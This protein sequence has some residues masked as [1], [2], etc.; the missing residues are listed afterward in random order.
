[1]GLK[2]SD[3]S[4]KFI[5]KSMLHVQKGKIKK[6]IK[7]LNKAMALDPCN[8]DIAHQVV[9]LYQRLNDKFNAIETFKNN[10]DFIEKEKEKNSIDKVKYNRAKLL[11]YKGILG[12]DPANVE[13]RISVAKSYL[14]RKK[15]RIAYIELYTALEHA[16]VMENAGLLEKIKSIMKE[17]KLSVLERDLLVAEFYHRIKDETAY[18]K[19][20]NR[21]EEKYKTKIKLL[22]GIYER[23]LNFYPYDE[24]IV[25]KYCMILI[26][27]KEYREANS[28]LRKV[29][30]CLPDNVSLQE[31]IG[32][33]AV[34]LGFLEE[35]M[36]RFQR[37]KILYERDGQ[38]E[39]LPLLMKNIELLGK[40]I[41]DKSFPEDMPP[42]PHTRTV[43]YGD[44]EAIEE[45]ETQVS[46][47]IE[48]EPDEDID[49]QV[50]EVD[51]IK[52]DLK[53]AAMREL[54]G[55]EEQRKTDSG[56]MKS[57]EIIDIGKELIEFG[58]VQE[59]DP[60]DV[61]KIDDNN[62]EVFLKFFGEIKSKIKDDFRACVD[63]GIA[64]QV[65]GFKSSASE[66][67]NMALKLKPECKDE[68]PQFNIKT[69][70]IAA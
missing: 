11:I 13:V 12:I 27:M 64:C 49:Q 39:K 23:H 37:L 53:E 5:S 21:L 60:L 33:T 28:L 30:A 51:E 42:L 2:D 26:K 18:R 35:A 63:M 44:R 52:P 62:P 4:K 36:Q 43:S 34:R 20:F 16:S 9:S 32:I 47:T 24:K 57:S 15:Y 8:I 17:V 58:R 19:C 65:M 55:Y 1:M 68:I 41:D 50:D 7:E 29:L 14:M 54:K 10:L 31:L 46:L 56:K 40:K 59:L 25:R 66:F 3:T 48:S 67:Y 69:R 38:K 45:L 22:R 70:K 61:I 6:A